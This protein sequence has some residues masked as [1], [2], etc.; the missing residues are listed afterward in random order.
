M[1][2]TEILITEADR[3]GKGVV[4][5][6]DTPGLETAAMQA[7]F[8]ELANDLLIPR[9][10]ALVEAL[11]GTQGASGIGTADGRTVEQKLAEKTGAADVLKKDNTEPFAPSGDYQPATKKYVDDAVFAAGAAD[12]RKAVYDNNDNGVVDDAEKLG[13]QLPSYYG[14]APAR[15][16]AT[17]TAAGWM[18][19]A[20]PYTQTVAVSGMLATDCP[21]IAPAYS[22][23]L[24]DAIA[25]KEAWAS[26]SD[27][28][29]GAGTI[30]FSCFEDR[31]AADIPIQVE[32]LR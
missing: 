12:M 13:G 30:T 9:H 19:E 1:N 14:Q 3:A 10:N 32:V 11:S 5:L 8:D 6:A 7:K 24:A 23:T 31:P 28:Q 16:A 15:Y 25:Q 20:A 4:G 22:D 29:A 26:V 2:L 18:G 27:A 21:H 17:L